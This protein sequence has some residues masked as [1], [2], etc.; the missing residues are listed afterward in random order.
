MKP[1]K[2]IEA[3]YWQSYL[4]TLSASAQP[5]NPHVEAAYAGNAAITDSLLALYLSGKK[6]AGSSVAEDF[7]SAGSPLPAVGNYWI[8]LNGKDEPGC[9]LRTERVVLHK[10]MDVPDEIAL[11]EGEGDLS[12]AYWREVH[13]RF[14]LP[15]LPGWGVS[16]IEDATVVTEFFRLVYR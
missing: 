6:F 8:L 10:F 16:R 5:E 4:A 12:L 3:R 7:A 2:P 15:Y 1:L 9:L 13:E 14:F 11:A